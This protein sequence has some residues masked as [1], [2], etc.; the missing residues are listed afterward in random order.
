MSEYLIPG[1]YEPDDFRLKHYISRC[2]IRSYRQMYYAGGHNRRSGD[3]QISFDLPLVSRD[4]VFCGLIFS[5]PLWKLI[6]W[7]NVL[8]DGDYIV[9]DNMSRSELRAYGG[10]I[11][12][13]D[14]AFV[15]PIQQVNDYHYLR[16]NFRL[17]SIEQHT[18][19]GLSALYCER[20]APTAADKALEKK[21]S[22]PWYRRL[23][24]AEK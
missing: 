10:F 5:A 8:R 6:E 15:L 14:R 9:R 17:E 20:Y 18:E 16:V 19:I 21:G 7:V 22:V 23:W 11:S 3:R 4:W 12:D 2:S 13:S 24:A 1:G